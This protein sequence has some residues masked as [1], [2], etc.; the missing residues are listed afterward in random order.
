MDKS[1]LYLVVTSMDKLEETKVNGVAEAQNATSL[2]D[3]EA[4]RI[5]Y[6]G[7]KGFFAAF[8]QELGKLSAEERPQRG[9]LINKAK[10]RL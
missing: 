2:Q 7:K 9:A 8:M 5:N 10:Q 6:L 1:P 3:L 4:V